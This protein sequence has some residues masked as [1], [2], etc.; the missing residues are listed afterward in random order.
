[1]DEFETKNQLL[2]KEVIKKRFLILPLFRTY[3]SKILFAVRLGANY[4]DP[5]PIA[6]KMEAVDW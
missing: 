2:F 3:I 5:L 6:Q 4:S 1:L